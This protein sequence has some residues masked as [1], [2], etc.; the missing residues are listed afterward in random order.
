MRRLFYFTSILIV[1]GVVLPLGGLLLVSSLAWAPA[2]AAIGPPPTDLPIEAVK[3]ESPSASQLSGW[4]IPGW[5]HM[6]SVVLVHGIRANRLAM[7]DRA[8]LLHRHGFTVLLFDFQ[9]H[10]ENPG[11]SIS[12]GYLESRD[13]GAAL[14]YLRH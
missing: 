3:F 9:G 5:P 13:A 11:R 2:P 7:L 4:F 12:F 1:G 8:R 6:G 14:E 10:G